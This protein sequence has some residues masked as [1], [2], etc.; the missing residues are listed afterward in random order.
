[1]FQRRFRTGWKAPDTV[2]DAWILLKGME[3]GWFDKHQFDVL[4][5]G[6]IDDA[7]SLNPP[8]LKQRKKTAIIDTTDSSSDDGISE[9]ALNKF[10]PRATS[11]PVSRDRNEKEKKDTGE[12]KNEEDREEKG[13]TDEEKDRNEETTKD[14]NGMIEETGKDGN[15]KQVEDDTVEDC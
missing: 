13:E 11:S 5:P 1:M 2:Y 8:K 12:E 4:F 15:K 10:H 14:G 9:R 7:A 6:V 3:R